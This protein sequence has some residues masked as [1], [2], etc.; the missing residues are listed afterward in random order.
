VT[1]AELN[2]LPAEEAWRALARCCGASVWVDQVCARRPYASLEAL[3]DGSEAAFARLRRDDWLEAFSHHP[4]IGDT[5][6]LR[7]RFATTSAWAGD[8]QKGAA[9][10]AEA[11]LLA[12]AE[13]N[14]AYEARFGHIFIVC[15]TGR[16]AAEMVALLSERLSNDPA[17][18]LRVAAA[19]QKKISALRLGKLIDR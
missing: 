12:L 19:E 1:L 4:R 11:T 10:A 16:T 15:A 7:E 8:E 9:G 2:A 5:A 18:E 17:D 13:G 14:A 3:R 6:E